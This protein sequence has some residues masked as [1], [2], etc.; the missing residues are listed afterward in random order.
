MNKILLGFFVVCVALYGAIYHYTQS[1]A[2]RSFDVLEKTVAASG[3]FTVLGDTDHDDIRLRYLFADDRIMAA[4]AKAGV[5]VL[6]LE[7]RAEF[8][9]DIDN[10]TSGKISKAEYINRRIGYYDA[11]KE[12]DPARRERT[13]Q[14]MTIG[15]DLM[16]NATRHGI[17]VVAA[18]KE[19][20]SVAAHYTT[21]IKYVDD[22]ETFFRASYAK[23]TN[24]LPMVEQAF[25]KY[26][27]ELS[28]YTGGLVA[29]DTAQQIIADN[30]TLIV[31]SSDKQNPEL[32]KHVLERKAILE[33]R[34]RGDI[35]LARF[36][37]E[38]AKGQKSV[39]FY[40]SS[41]GANECDL[42]DYLKASRLTL[43]ATKHEAITNFQR[44]YMLGVGVSDALVL[45]TGTVLKAA[46]YKSNILP[47]APTMPESG[48]PQLCIY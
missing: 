24:A 26:A 43:Y 32:F 46:D 12:F 25:E 36:I 17:H 5:K 16:E 7:V 48:R 44:N 29:L 45:N 9:D 14:R 4:F 23:R 47:D 33:E 15:A 21:A 3:Q 22:L 18:E 38:Q 20:A 27:F 10:F 8:Q 40:G 28:M 41:H 11:M 35:D 31:T 2:Q 19:F 1:F 30:L 37:Q 39:V 34:L 6:F 42:D 13:L